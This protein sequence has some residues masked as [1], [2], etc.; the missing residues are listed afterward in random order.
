MDPDPALRPPGVDADPGP[1][2]ESGARAWQGIPGLERTPDGRLWATWYS[3]GE[4]EGPENYVVLVASD[5]GGRTWGTPRLVVDPP[6]Q[7]RAFDP[8]LWVDPLDRLWLFWAQET[9]KW[10]GRAGVWAVTRTAAGWS[11]ARRLCD[12]IMLNKP[13]VLADGTWLFPA[14]R[15]DLP[16]QT[17]RYRD[18][19]RL[20]DAELDARTAP[21]DVGQVPTTVY[22]SRDYGQSLQRRGGAQVPGPCASP[23]EHQVVERRDGSLWMLVRATYGIGESVSSDGGRTWTPV[24]AAGIEHPESRFFIRRLR[25]GN[26]LLVRHARPDART[27]LTAFLSTDDGASWT[28]GLR[29][30]DRDGVSYPDGVQDPDGLIRV[31]YDRDRT[32]AGEILTASFREADVAAGEAVSGDVERRRVVDALG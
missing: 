28:G 16:P 6:G 1:A 18:T 13:T 15:W 23:N 4:T 5:D 29:L 7:V 14:T 8:C 27:A 20:T 22:A 32:G 9:L 30:D 21:V 19:G 11:D 24:R 12:G 2:Y 3:G 26:L 25:S 31:V 10:D 17:G